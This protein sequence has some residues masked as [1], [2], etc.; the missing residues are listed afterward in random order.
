MSVSISVIT[1]C[2]NAEATIEQTIQGV[3]SQTYPHIE[4]IVI[5]GASS[6]RTLDLIKRYSDH[7]TTLISEPDEGVYQAMNKGIRLA[8]GDWLYFANAD[9]Y[10]FGAEAIADVAAF[11]AENPDCDFVYGDHETR[12]PWGKRSTYSPASPDNALEQLISLGNC[13]I[14][15]ASFFKAHLFEKIGLFNESYRIASDYEWFCQMLS[16]PDIQIRYF[17]RIIVSYFQGGL[18]SDIPS[19][20]EEVFAIQNSLPIYQQPEWIER[21]MKSLQASFIEKYDRLEKSNR[22]SM[23]R[24]KRIEELDPIAARVP[25]L[26][27]RIKVLTM[28]YEQQISALNTRIAA[29]ESSKFWKLREAWL[30]L[31]RKLGLPADEE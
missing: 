2:R 8:K 13:F 27:D 30:S 17:P 7:I 25:G 11:I 31:K 23:K 6:D 21:R 26:L 9:D 4:Y 16:K 10:L 15:P 12:F 29:M 18:S 20:F 19:L 14:Q 24:L 5:D 22:L 28:D 3:I 1:V